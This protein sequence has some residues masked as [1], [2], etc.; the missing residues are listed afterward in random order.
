MRCRQPIDQAL[1]PGRIRPAELAG[2]EIEIVDDLRQVAESRLLEIET[3]T[4]RLERASIAFVREIRASHVERLF[5]GANR[6]TGGI[7]EAKPCGRIDEAANQP[8]RG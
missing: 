2:L 1:N 4:H 3:G 8:C 5:A 6:S 7:D